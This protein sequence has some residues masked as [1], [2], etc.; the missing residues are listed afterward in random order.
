MVKFSF[1]FLFFFFVVKSAEV[2]I[3]ATKYSYLIIGLEDE[4][5]VFKPF[6]LPFKT[7]FNPILQVHWTA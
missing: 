7:W 2:A 5:R 4:L 3:F 1:F 6:W